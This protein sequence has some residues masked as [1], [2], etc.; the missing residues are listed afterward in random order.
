MSAV[1]GIDLSLVRTGM[2]SW[3]DGQMTTHSVGHGTVAAKTYRDRNRRIISQL[4]AVVNAIHPPRLTT[5]PT[6]IDL[7][8]I[9]GPILHGK[10]LPSYFDRAQLW[11]GVY[12]QLAAWKIPVAVVDPMTLKMF[13]TGKGNA[14][15]AMMLHEAR[16]SW[17]R[18][19]NADEADSAWLA[20]MG[21]A[22]LGDYP[23]F[24]LAPWRVAGLTRVEWPD[25][26]RVGV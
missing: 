13:A 15:K 18:I 8:V 3:C 2:A 7:A 10:M 20:A 21:L 22:Q 11:G 14:D 25:P 16:K 24:A 17:P 6:G 5:P 1:I 12:S 19:A 23:P 4:T 26:P 9:E